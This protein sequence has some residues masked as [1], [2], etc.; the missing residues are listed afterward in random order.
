MTTGASGPAEPPL[1]IVRQLEIMR[2]KLER[3]RM[4]PPYLDTL[5]MTSGTPCPAPSLRIL[6]RKIEES[7]APHAGRRKAHHK[8]RKL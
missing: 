2:E 8:L 6:L 4:S 3:R 7:A 1:P 5:Y